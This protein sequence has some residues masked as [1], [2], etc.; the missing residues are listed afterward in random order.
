[1][2]LIVTAPYPKKGSK[3]KKKIKGYKAVQSYFADVMPQ[4][5]TT[6]TSISSPSFFNVREIRIRAGKLILIFYKI[7]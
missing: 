7:Q 6:N 5:T 3:K 4:V 1:L 2:E